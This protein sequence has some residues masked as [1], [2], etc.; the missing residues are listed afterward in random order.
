MSFKTV[1]KGLAFSLIFLAAG[2]LSA[3]DFPSLDKS[4]MDVAS[5]PDSP[6]ESNK[7]VKV[8]YSRPQLDGREVSKLAEYG[9]VWRTGANEAAE[10]TFYVDMTLDGKSIPAGTYSLYTIGGDDEWT[11]I[12]N[13]DLN[14][15][16]AYFYKEANDLVRATVSASSADKSIEAFSLVFTEAD[17]GV[18]LHLG[19]GNVRASFPFKKG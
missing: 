14:T 7:L 16:G 18:D 1:L 8:Q 11:I 13:K 12:I 10:I 19:W 4:P 3:Q 17:G 9:N 6:R 5:F 15:W 2:T